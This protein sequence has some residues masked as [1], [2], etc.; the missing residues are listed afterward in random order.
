MTP[1]ELLSLLRC[2]HCGGALSGRSCTL[3]GTDFPANAAGQMDMRPRATLTRNVPFAVDAN[4]PL[5]SPR[6]EDAD[7]GIAPQ[8]LDL[9]T[10]IPPAPAGGAQALEI[11]C[12]HN[13]LRMLIERAG[14]TY[15]SVDYRSDIADALAD[16]HAL[17]FADGTFPLVA[18]NALLEHVR[19]PHLAAREIARVAASGGR[20]V[21]GVAFLQPF[22]D[23]Y[24]HLTHAAVRDLFAG[25]G[26]T[27][28]AL[29]RIPERFLPY[30]AVYSNLPFPFNTLVRILITP[31]DL[32]HTLLLKLKQRIRKRRDDGSIA[33]AAA[34]IFAATKN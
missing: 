1:T 27:V 24:F 2:S 33:L 6:P 3:C 28:T 16:V 30:L 17:P 13:S 12:G 25:A 15:V 11:G 21:G 34:I 23:S 9:S 8:P 29:G 5:W 10:L 19:Y 18:C 31:A 32:V 22:H 4:D 20:V 7:E 26:L 14:W